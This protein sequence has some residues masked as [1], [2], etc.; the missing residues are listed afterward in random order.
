MKDDERASAPVSAPH[1]PAQDSGRSP[2][3]HVIAPERL[4]GQDPGRDAER[5]GDET[6]GR[7]RR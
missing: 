2:D 7:A 5:E 6:D 1:D 4:V 3:P